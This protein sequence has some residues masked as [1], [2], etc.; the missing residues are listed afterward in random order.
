MTHICVYSLNLGI[1][2]EFASINL[3][4]DG[5]DGGKVVGDSVLFSRPW[6]A[7]GVRYRKTKLLLAVHFREALHQQVDEGALCM[8]M[9]RCVQGNANRSDM[10]W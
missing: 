3:L 4:L 7:R 9:W 6:I 8:S 5:L 1:L 10:G 2:Q